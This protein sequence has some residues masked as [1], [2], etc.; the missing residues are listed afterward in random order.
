MRYQQA[1]FRHV[2]MKVFVSRI[3]ALL[4]QG[5]EIAAQLS[6]GCGHLGSGLRGCMGLLV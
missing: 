6:N 5:F 1:S 4:F 3:L 2:G